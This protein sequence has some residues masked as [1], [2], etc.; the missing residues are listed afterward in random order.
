MRFIISPAKKMRIAHDDF[1]A[2]TT[3]FFVDE[4]HEV[5]RALMD[6]SPHELQK[7]WSVSD[8]LAEENRARLAQFD[9]SAP[10]LTPALFAYSG[11]Q[12]QHLAPEV[13]EEDALEY[14]ASHLRII[15][16]MY[17]VL[18]PFDGIAPY[19]LEMQAKLS[20]K[21]ARNLYQ[22][23]G[24]KLASFLESEEAQTSG[25]AT[26]V[27]VNLASAEYAKAVIPHLSSATRVITCTFASKGPD[28]SLKVRATAAKTARGTMVRYCAQKHITHL[29]ELKAFDVLGYRF[30]PQ[31]STEDELVFVMQ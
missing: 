22:F 26:P 28:D 16:G 9:P 20:L 7:L 8:S 4:A 25:E 12:Y 19:R 21:Q 6:L 23:W 2:R 11:L 24:H 31:S 13:L 14:V 10:H 5:T 15:S 17:G 27:I 29:E 1:V 3:P 18:R 30:C